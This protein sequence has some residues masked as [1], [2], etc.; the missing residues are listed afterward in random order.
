MDSLRHLA[1]HLGL[2][3]TAICLLTFAIYL[4]EA[5]AARPQC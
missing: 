1:A 3:L 5:P 4:S 2:D